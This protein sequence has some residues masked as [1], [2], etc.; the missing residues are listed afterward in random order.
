MTAKHLCDG[1][2]ALVVLGA[3]HSHVGTSTSPFF[4]CVAETTPPGQAG[5]ASQIGQYPVDGQT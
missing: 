3:A 4:D 5:L 1:R 2:R